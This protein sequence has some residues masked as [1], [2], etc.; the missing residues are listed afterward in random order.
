MKPQPLKGAADVSTSS[1]GGDVIR[2]FYTS[3]PYPPPLDNLDR[4]RD[5]G[6]DPN[7]HRAEYHLLWPH[8]EYHADLDVLI[9]GCGTWQAAKF[10]LTHPEARVTGID[11]APTSLQHTEALKQKYDLTN[12]EV[13]PLGIENAGELDHQFELIICTGVLHHL[14]DPDEGLRALRSV[15]RPDGAM[16]LML[17]APYGRTGVSMFQEYCRILGIGTSQP[18]ISE[19]TATLS[20]L[21]QHHPLVAMFRGARDS[22]NAG[23]L[24]DALLNPRDRTYS[25]PG[26]YDFVERNEMRLARWYWQAPYSPLCGAL[27]ETPHAARLAA[28]PERDR[29][30]AVEL[31]RGLISNHDFIAYRNDAP[32]AELQVGFDDDRYLNY[33]PIRRAWT[34]CVQEQLPPGAAGVLVNQ[35]HMFPDLFLIVDALEKKI[36]ESID[37]QRNIGAIVEFLNGSSARARDF[38]EKLW[39]YDQ[40]VFNTSKA[41]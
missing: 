25:V 29:Y 27:A 1:D 7:T 20:L 30:K 15:L 36:Y 11:V 35:T 32:A 34:M 8:R 17:Y 5:L 14:V 18:E 4:A 24:I 12:L 23:A 3:H 28:L 21:P 26:L 41:Q 2:E 10:A 22:L 38:F 16:Y 40:V 9:A 39:L 37:G 31:W 6:Q 33:V 13:H 19:L